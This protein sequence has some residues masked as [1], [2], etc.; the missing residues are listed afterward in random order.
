K[1]FVVFF[2]S[3]GYVEDKNLFLFDGRGEN[4]PANIDI[5]INAKK[6][7]TLVQHAL[8][9]NGAHKVNLVAHSM[10]G[11]IS[12]WYIEQMGGDTTVNKLIMLGTPNHG[13][14][15]LP[16]LT[17]IVGYIDDRLEEREIHKQKLEQMKE[18]NALHL[19]IHK[20]K[21]KKDKDKHKKNETPATSDQNIEQEQDT[22]NWFDEKTEESIDEHIQ[23]VVA[24]NDIDHLGMAAVQMDPGSEF[25]TTLGYEGK[26]NYY[27]VT[28]TKGFP[29]G[30]GG[31]LPEGD[32][33]GVVHADSVDLTEVPVAHKVTFKVSHMQL[34]YK[35]VTFNQI[36][37]FLVL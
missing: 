10:G 8:T 31:Y 27:L 35:V 16:L 28:G 19:A 22:E 30:I 20:L 3:N 17:R 9:L 32:N 2:E 7:Q 5:R 26:D 23:Q 25:L 33:D 36:M 37:N 1:R 15:Y 14:K 13:S 4:A 11:L 24:E 29:T 18:K 6:L 34:F 12:R 21:D